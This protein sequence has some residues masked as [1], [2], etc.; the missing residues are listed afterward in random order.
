MAELVIP[1]DELNEPQRET[2]DRLLAT[3]RGMHYA[4]IVVRRDGKDWGFEADFLSKATIREA[5]DA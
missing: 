1:L 4:D 2:V 3:V 5:R